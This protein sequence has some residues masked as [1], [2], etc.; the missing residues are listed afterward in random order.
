MI[1]NVGRISTQA[2][3]TERVVGRKVEEEAIAGWTSFLYYV[4]ATKCIS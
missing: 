1:G 2:L 4:S 3:E